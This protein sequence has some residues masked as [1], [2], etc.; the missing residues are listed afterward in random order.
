MLEESG[1]LS[2]IELIA[3]LTRLKGG[4]RPPLSLSLVRKDRRA[5]KPLIPYI[6]VGDRCL[7]Q[8]PRVIGAL[9]A[10]T[11]GGRKAA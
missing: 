7:Y 3:E 10:R 4:G 1:F 6:R 9:E 8:L 2:D 5:P 11:R